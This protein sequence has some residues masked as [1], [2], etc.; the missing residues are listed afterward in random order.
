VLAGAAGSAD[1]LIA[2][3]VVQGVG[4]AALLSLSLALTAHA[5]PGDQ[6]ARAL[7]IWAAVS[8]VALA[9]GPLVGGAL[10]EAASW[11]WIFFM[12]VPIAVAGIAV[13]LL[14]GAE[15][16]DPDAASRVDVAGAA[17]LAIG[18]TACV[19]A[20]VEADEWPAAALLALAAV[21]AAAL[22]GFWKLE[23]RRTN[24]LVDFSLFRNRPYLGASAAAFALVG[25]YWSVMFFEPQYLQLG[26]GHSAVAAG[27]MVLPITVPMAVFSP[28]SGALIG[29][30]G[31]RATMTT[32]MLIGLAGLIL[33]VAGQDSG[34][35]GALLPGFLCF[36]ISLALV[37]APMSTAAM[38]AMPA[39][40]AGIASGVLAM[41]RVLA[42]TVMLA[43]SGAVFQSKPASDYAD[44]VAR[45][46]VP[47]AVVVAAGAL[48]TWLLV[49]APAS[50][51]TPPPVEPEHRQHHRRFHL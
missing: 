39:A 31:V 30:L 34:S 26:L 41:D 13:L 4:G 15:S 24:P 50:P 35:Y 3:R 12:N 28:F 51:T 17:V 1:V 27:A 25:A 6:Q 33:I 8:A 38:A 48:L 10:I 5:F 42:G 44:A 21:G 45:A 36:G 49:R 43:V 9:I 18:L 2:G 14:R 22:F 7:G 23:H 32:G 29:R 37:Y 40:K 11:R 16:R 47:G 19:L 46:L 20:L